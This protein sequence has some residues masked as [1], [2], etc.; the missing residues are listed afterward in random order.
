[1]D[2]AQLAALLRLDF[3][4]AD[5]GDSAEQFDQR[6]KLLLDVAQ[7]RSGVTPA[8]QEAGVRYHLL[9]AQVRQLTRKAESL[10]AASGASISQGLATRL[11]ELRTQMAEQL[12]LSGL[13]PPPDPSR[14][15]RGSV[16]VPVEVVH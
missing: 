13:Q 14:R 12:T 9:S 16:N 5:T 2:A 11:A 15:V 4:P 7:A 1:M 6:L 10:K 3:R 8:Q